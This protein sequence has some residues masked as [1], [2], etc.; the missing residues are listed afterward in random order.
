MSEET[1]TLVDC[2]RNSQR[3]QFEISRK[4]K[5]YRASTIQRIGVV[6]K[7]S[8]ILSLAAAVKKKKGVNKELLEELSQALGKSQQNVAAFLR[9]DGA[10]QA[11]C[12][13]LT[14]LYFLFLFHR[15]NCIV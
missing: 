11:L 7:S 10:L 9:T 4:E 1:D 12:S 15:I 14:G 3:K 13:F 2:L 6:E 5:R 8:N